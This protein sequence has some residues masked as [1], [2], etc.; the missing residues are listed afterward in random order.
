MDL[1]NL[2]P[3]LRQQPLSF[4]RRK[5]TTISPS[6][7][8]AGDDLTSTL[9]RGLTSPPYQSITIVL[10]VSPPSVLTKPFGHAHL[11]S[12]SSITH[13]RAIAISFHVKCI[14]LDKKGDWRC[15]GCKA[16]REVV[17]TG[18]WCFC[19]STSEPKPLRLATPHS[20]GSSCSRPRESGWC[21][22]G[23]C[24]PCQ[25]TTRPELLAFRCG[26]DA[27]AGRDLS[28]GNICKRT[29]GCKKHSCER[30][31]RSGECNKCPVKDLARCRCGKEEKEIGC[32][33]GKEEQCFVEGQPPWIGRFSCDQGR[34]L[35]FLYYK[36]FSIV[37][38]INVKNRVIQHDPHLAICPRSPSKITHWPCGKSTIAPTSAVDQSIY[39]FSSRANCTSPIPTCDS[40][41]S[42]HNP[43]C[44][45]PCKAKCH[46]GPCP[47][48]PAYKSSYFSAEEK[49]ILCDRPCA[50]LRACGRHQCRRICCPLASLANA[51]K[52]GHRRVEDE[53]II[54]EEYGGLYECDLV[55]GEMLPWIDHKGTCRPC[56][57]SSFEELVC[58]CDL[59]VYDPPIPCGT[60][61][62][63]FYPCLRP[64]PPCGHPATSHMCHGDTSVPKVRCSLETEKVSCGNVDGMW[65]P[66]LCHSDECGNCTAPCGKARKYR[67]PD[68][69]PCA[70][71][72][73]APSSCPETEPCESL[74]ILPC[75]SSRIRQSVLCGQ[76][77]SQRSSS[78]TRAA[79]KCS[80]DCQIAKQNARLADALGITL[81]GTKSSAAMAVTYADELSG[82]ARVNPK[83]LSL[84]E[85]T[86][87]D[88]ITSE[89]RTNVLPH[90]PPDSRKFVHDRTQMLDQEPH[91]SVQGI[92]RI[93]TRIPTP[94]LSTFIA[95][96]PG[97]G[98]LADF[99][100]L[101]A[102]TPS[103]TSWRS[104]AATSTSSHPLHP[105]SE[106]GRLATTS[107][108][109]LGGSQDSSLLGAGA[110]P[111]GVSSRTVSPAQLLTEPVPENW[112]EDV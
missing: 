6:S 49:E 22:P 66:S 29:L 53:P 55:C 45:H 26:I 64:A 12:L 46:V 86:F 24:P 99:R 111:S 4:N 16:K 14:Q 89:K 81:E 91:R 80:N 100:A 59:T 105:Q 103:T 108:E 41:C 3:P 35:T 42:K 32:G 38:F 9:I 68:H 70:R 54:G 77:V 63:C 93:E 47:P 62:Q 60:V 95:P 85:R 27:N 74:I 82:F 98:K 33:E 71:T 18:Y 2:K 8:H 31:C 5:G 61:M 101:K 96:A 10:S 11:E 20:C 48:C 36:R 102:T 107:S 19:H 51:G 28:C 83:F 84:V 15:P 25:I 92:R 97:L 104:T 21:H 112:E 69:H 90:M 58:S 56:M 109:V 52:K 23:P 67:L 40:V 34:M 106:A 30:V 17:P 76:T 79:P 78:H 94:L 43:T 110:G 37:E 72:C 65:V 13:N 44:S 57:R 50:A 88:F 1:P 87:A 7:N 39:A 73:H 75:P